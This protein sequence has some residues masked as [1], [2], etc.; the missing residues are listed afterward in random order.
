MIMLRL[1]LLCS[2]SG[3]IAAISP[4]PTG[5]HISLAADTTAQLI[6]GEKVFTNNCVSCHQSNGLGVPNLA[7]PLSE[8]EYVTGD[9]ERLI[10]IVLNGFNEDVEIKGEYYSNPMPS[11][12][13]LTDEEIADVLTFVRNSFNNQAAAITPEEVA[14]Q[15]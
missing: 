13:Y 7:P 5:S 1:L 11:F 14:S 6:N 8:T 4:D 15:R 2:L 3:L 9:K 12:D 10:G